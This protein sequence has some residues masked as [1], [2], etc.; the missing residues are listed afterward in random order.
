MVNNINKRHLHCQNL[1]RSSLFEPIGF[2]FWWHPLGHPSERVW[3]WQD[4]L[5]RA[6]KELSELELKVYRAMR[7]EPMMRMAWIHISNIINMFVW[8]LKTCFKVVSSFERPNWT[9]QS[10]FQIGG[11][12]CGNRWW[13]RNQR[14][15]KTSLTWLRCQCCNIG[16]TSGPLSNAEQA[17]NMVEKEISRV[18]GQHDS[19]EQEARVFWWVFF[20][21]VALL[22]T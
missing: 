22:K 9:V 11:F 19:V 20:P 7:W 6:A 1:P 2:L 4:D 17:R 15:L 8:I 14:W 10:F 16:D 21:G 18:Q 3:D 12:V 5:A 13:R